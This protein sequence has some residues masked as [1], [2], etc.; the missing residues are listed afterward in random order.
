MHPAADTTALIYL[1]R[2]RAADD[3]WCRAALRRSLMS[4]INN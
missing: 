2:S 3:A 1:Q 4:F